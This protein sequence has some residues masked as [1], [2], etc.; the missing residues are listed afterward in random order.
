MIYIF[1]LDLNVKET[2][3]SD[4]MKMDEVLFGYEKVNGN[5]KPRILVR[6]CTEYKAFDNLA[7]L[8]L[9]K[10]E[11]QSLQ[12]AEII[13]CINYKEHNKIVQYLQNKFPEYAI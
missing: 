6:A 11:S 8:F 3:D 4:S 9:V 7:N 5:S 10:N 1:D 13:N 12:A 2:E